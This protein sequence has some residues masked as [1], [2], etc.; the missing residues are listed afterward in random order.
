M[1]NVFKAITVMACILATPTAAQAGGRIFDGSVKDSSHYA[2]VYNWTGPYVGAAIG[3]SWTGYDFTHDVFLAPSY[4]VTRTTGPDSDGIT[5][6]LTIGYDHQ[7]WSNVLVGVFADFTF[8]DHDVDDRIFYP[9]F[10]EGVRLSRGNAW[11]IGGRIGYI[12]RPDLMGYFS[13]GYTR[14]EYELTSLAGNGSL[15]EDLDGYFLGVGMVTML[16]GGFGLSLDYRYSNFEEERLGSSRSGSCCFEAF[17]VGSDD[18]SGRA[19][20]TFNF[21][22]VAAAAPYVPTK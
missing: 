14:G 3:Y 17:D 22:G 21:G 15:D 20:I 2:P 6:T 16:G 13:A 11:A 4:D 12:F 7:I 9:T 10:S 5:G 19:G 18:H 1:K 8:A